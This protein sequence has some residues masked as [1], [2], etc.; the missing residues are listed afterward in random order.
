MPRHEW[1]CEKC[2]KRVSVLRSIGDHANEPE[3][4]ELPKGKCEHEWKKFIGAAPTAQFGSSW[5]PYG[6]TSHK[7]KW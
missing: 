2:K 5:G 7:G 1:K 6:G 3:G 4:E